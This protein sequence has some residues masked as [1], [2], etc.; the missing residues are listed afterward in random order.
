MVP[1]VSE[2]EAKVRI[3]RR[4]AEEFDGVGHGLVI[5]LGVG[6]P[7]LVADYIQ[8]ADVF[9]QAEN[10]ILGVGPLA[11]GE[12]IDRQLINAGRQPVTE[13][14]GCSYFDS[15]ASFGMI[16]G[17]HVDAT[18]IGAFQVDQE[19][20]IAN[21][22]IPNGK[23]LGV[24]GAM[25]LITGARQVIIG[26]QHTTRDG[27]PKLVKRCTLPV[28]GFAEADLVVTELGLFAFQNGKLILREIAPEVT[29]EA[30]TA[31][32][33]AAFITAPGLKTMAA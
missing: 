29:V 26:M 19:A 15:A 18:V 33:E 7:T 13:T 27:K 22:I 10:G 14:P 5:N 21:W 11:V 25:D 28:T 9:I 31:L 4:I 20:N 6:I 23:Q 2:E 3:A 12:R 30:L 32:T 1:L 8:K 17:G 24:G 16:R